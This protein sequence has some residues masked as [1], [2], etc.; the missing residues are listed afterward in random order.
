MTGRQT[1]FCIFCTFSERSFS[2][3]AP[4]PAAPAFLLLLLAEGLDGSSVEVCDKERSNPELLQITYRGLVAQFRKTGL[5]RSRGSLSDC[6]LYIQGVLKRLRRKKH[7]E[8]STLCMPRLW[9]LKCRLSAHFTRSTFSRSPSCG[10]VPRLLLSP[11]AEQG[12]QKPCV[13]ALT[14]VRVT[15]LQP[16][17][18]SR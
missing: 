2:A 15:A 8:L 13:S 1:D 11:L 6:E 4:G 7:Q 10:C 12:D 16:S 3:S 9:M 18:P 17:C 14:Y 5:T